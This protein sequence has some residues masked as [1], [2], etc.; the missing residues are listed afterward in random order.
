MAAQPGVTETVDTLV[1]DGKTLR[2]SIDQTASG[3]ARFIAKVSL[4]SNTLGVAIAPNTYATVVGYRG[5]G[6]GVM[7]ALRIA[8]LNLLRLA[9]FQSIRE[10]LQAVM[11]DIKALLVMAM[12]LPVPN[13]S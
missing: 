11:H 8:A 10:G 2:G 6:A 7:A 4:Y 3:A 1:T 5:S 13:P 9:G 12:S